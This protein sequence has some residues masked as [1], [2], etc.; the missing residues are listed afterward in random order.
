MSSCKR[1]HRIECSLPPVE[2]ALLCLEE[3]LEMG[4]ERYTAELLANPKNPRVGLAERVEEGVRKFSTFGQRELVDRAVREAQK[5]ADMRLVLI[6]NLHD[7]VRRKLS[8]PQIELIEE[9]FLR[10]SLQT[11]VIGHKPK[12][13]E[14]WRAQLI[15]RLIEK[16]CLK[17][18]VEL[19]SVKYYRGHAMLFKADEDLLN[20][21]TACL[22]DLMEDY[23]KN[24]GRLPGGKRI[25]LEA[26]SS[27]IADNAKG[28]AGN[29]AALARA[30]TLM[31]FGEEQQAREHLDS[32]AH[33]ARRELD[34]LR[35]LSQQDSLT[36]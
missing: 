10:I 12:S 15:E 9:R 23:N 20:S 24:E 34:R 8:V 27:Q 31:M 7:H 11:S 4:Q 2:A 17:K 19:I 36:C 21:Q 16:L 14:L 29:L 22:R 28:H 35:S 6:L 18:T 5:Q 13:W 1:S 33:G 32:T 3:M 25:D 30:R 26:F